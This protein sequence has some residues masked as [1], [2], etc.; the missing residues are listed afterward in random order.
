ML[1]RRREAGQCRSLLRRQAAF[2]DFGLER[3]ALAALW[4]IARSGGQGAI[5]ESS[6]EA[7]AESYGP[8]VGIE[9]I[10]V[11]FKERTGFDDGWD[12]VPE[13]KRGDENNGQVWD[14]TQWRGEV[15]VP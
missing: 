7:T 3:I 1:R 8:G 13:R 2:R 5:T 9:V 6:W 10:P 15:A 14:L 4:Q 11:I 12:V